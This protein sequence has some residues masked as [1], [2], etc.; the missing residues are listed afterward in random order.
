MTA[1]DRTALRDFAKLIAVEIKHC[2]CYKESAFTFSIIIIIIITIIII[3][4]III[5]SIVNKEAV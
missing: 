1:L 2:F 4:L 5:K 3:I